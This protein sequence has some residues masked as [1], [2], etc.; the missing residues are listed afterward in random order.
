MSASWGEEECN[1]YEK[2][3]AE[4]KLCTLY[5]VAEGVYYFNE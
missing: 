1:K 4:T 3:Q 2:L 5:I